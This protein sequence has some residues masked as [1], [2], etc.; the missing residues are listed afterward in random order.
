MPARRLAVSALALIAVV[1]FP[2]TSTGET[3]RVRAAGSTPTD[4]SWMPDSRH[5][6]TGNRVLWRNP[7]DATH[8]VVA[9]SNNWSKNSAIAPG[10]TTAK[11]F[12]NRGRYLY[13]CTRPGHST[14]SNGECEG[15]C[16]TIH[17]TR[18]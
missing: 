10:E 15:M 11:R 12:P 18:S 6:T 7:T 9:Y 8:R 5:I 14:L 3:F 2:G 1:A 13:R 16:G 4:F 17:V